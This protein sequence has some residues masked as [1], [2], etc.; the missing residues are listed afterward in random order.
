MNAK[1]LLSLFCAVA[2]IACSLLS[3]CSAAGGQTIYEPNYHTICGNLPYHKL[4]PKGVSR[5]YINNRQTLYLAHGNC[6]QCENCNLIVV[7]EGDIYFDYATNT[8]TMTTIG[9]WGILPYSEK[10]TSDINWISTNTYGYCPTNH[11]DGYRFDYY[12]Y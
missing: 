2:L 3:P 7:T 9:K 8:P 1:K 5:I 4:M 10:L 11:M 6:W 12:H